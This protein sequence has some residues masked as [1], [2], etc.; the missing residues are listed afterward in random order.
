MSTIESQAG[1]IDA[2]RRTR[3]PDVQLP[4]VTSTLNTPGLAITPVASEGMQTAESLLQAFSSINGA[5]AAIVR[6]RNQARAE[7]DRQAVIDKQNQ[8]EIDTAERGQANI[9]AGVDLPAMLSGIESGTIKPNEGESV[10]EAARRLALDGTDGLSE[11]SKDQRLARLSDNLASALQNRVDKNVNLA[12]SENVYLAINRI[13]G[14]T[15]PTDGYDAVQAIRKINPDISEPI[16]TAEVGKQW[17]DYA[18]ANHDTKALEAAKKFLGDKMQTEQAI[19]QSRYDAEV[20][21]RENRSLQELQADVGKMLDANAPYSTVRAF[22]AERGKALG[23][24]VHALGR[25]VDTEHAVLHNR[26]DANESE[27][28]QQAKKAAAD[29]V[30]TQIIAGD[31]EK[32]MS[33]A[34]DAG[35]PPAFRLNLL[36]N[37]D[38]YKN[39]QRIRKDQAQSQILDQTA[40]EVSRNILAGDFAGAKKAALSAKDL[41]ARM[42]LGL[43]DKADA[44]E[45]EAK[46]E[47]VRDLMVQQRAAHTEA[48]AARASTFVDNGLANLIQDFQYALPDDSEHTITAKK[49]REQ[50]MAGKFAQIAEANK[51]NP[52]TAL[53]LQMKAA[54]DNAYYPPAW[55]QLIEGA[56]A[57][58]SIN[59]IAGTKDGKLPTDVLNGY[60]FF[61]QMTARAPGL[62]DSMNISSR[63]K[64]L[65]SAAMELEKMP[66]VGSDPMTALTTAA[67]VVD[68][69]GTFLDTVKMGAIAAK[70]DITSQRDIEVAREAAPLARILTRIGKTPADAVDQAVEQ[71]KKNRI[72]INGWSTRLGNV[73]PGMKY[74]FADAA[75]MKLKDFAGT[76]ADTGVDHRDLA[77]R[78]NSGTDLWEIVNRHTGLSVPTNNPDTTFFRTEQLLQDA[79]TRKEDAAKAEFIKRQNDRRATDF[80]FDYKGPN[81]GF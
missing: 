12:K 51:G 25:E 14:S 44:H 73:P 35:V 1:P 66:A 26:R 55:K 39:Q 45:E 27:A 63:T 57:K 19:A 10:A 24:D 28:E 33:A 34:N 17:L 64:E 54:S 76:L 16:A 6:Q 47:A 41:P 80:R 15:D 23:V 53:E 43:F 48:A 50:A 40:D 18:V 61:K 67:N 77:M 46:R 74:Q 81:R 2:Y 20:Q 42:I 37:I 8:H 22:I 4:G 62:L 52:E 75:E 68:D 5:S 65:F 30:A 70:L 31:F 32:A 36:D 38:S 21:R 69:P 7:A 49:L 71:V 78:Y 59:A 60:Q 29:A 9:N 3:T 79:T 56:G 58:T 72:E 13:E 11:V